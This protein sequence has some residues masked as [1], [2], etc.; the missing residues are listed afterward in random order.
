MDQTILDSFK[1][2]VAEYQIR[3][4]LDL[5]ARVIRDLSYRPYSPN[6]KQME[7]LLQEQRFHEV[8]SIMD[9]DRVNLLLSP[10]AHYLTSVAMRH[11]EMLQESNAEQYAASMTAHGIL[12][13]GDGS[14]QKPY[15]ITRISDEIDIANALKKKPARQT[16]IQDPDRTLDRVEY[17]DATELYFDNTPCSQSMAQFIAEE[18]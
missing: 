17:E 11:L 18:E 16:Y 13:S 6:L 10:R 15:L 4:F 2:L 5:R 14:F 12:D 9:D 7:L 1:K 3:E 8:L